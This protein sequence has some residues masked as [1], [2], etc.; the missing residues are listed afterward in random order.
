MSKILSIAI[1]VGL[2]GLPSGLFGQ[3]DVVVEVQEVAQVEGVIVADGAFNVNG[4]ADEG[5]QEKAL[6]NARDGLRKDLKK[7]ASV[8]VGFARRVCQ[9]DKDQLQQLNQGI[10][11]RLE[12]S[13]DKLININN[14]FQAGIGFG[15]GNI[16]ATT[17]SGQSLTSDPYEVVRQAVAAEMAKLV[18]DDE[19]ETY[20]REAKLRN[21]YRRNA[22]IELV[23]EMLH[24]H[25]SL[26][27]EQR[28][29]LRRS[30]DKRWEGAS[31]FSISMYIHNPEY[32][33]QLPEVAVQ[34]VLEKD[35][36]IIWNS[37]NKYSFPLEVNDSE[38]GI[39]WDE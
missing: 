27:S 29:K 26:S 10:A 37:L 38:V 31:S 15:G 39:Q 24:S 11:G 7:I 19:L 17:S 5:D 35:Q 16:V 22:A 21:E 34:T 33:P 14:V 32:V 8:E 13:L 12:E 18:A 23:I 9:L 36:R 4:Q 2:T 1:L 25:L 20:Q 6:K 28:E 30:L 3:D